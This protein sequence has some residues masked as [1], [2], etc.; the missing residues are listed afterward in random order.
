ME[1][2][3]RLQREG[4]ARFI[5]LSGHA[6]PIARQAARDGYVDV[7]M[8]PVNLAAG[9]DTREMLELCAGLD[10]AVVAMKPFAGGEMFRKS[11]AVPVTAVRCLSYTLSQTGV[12]AVVPGVRDVDEL[13]A[14]QAYLDAPAEARDFSGL[15]AE[16]QHD[17]QGTCVYCNHCLP[18][19]VGIEIAEILRLVKAA[20]DGVTPALR[21]AYQALAATAS[22]CTN[23]GD[24]ER[25]CPFGVPIVERLGR[26]VALFEMA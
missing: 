12:S 6:N 10:V 23:C 8:Q 26:A 3:L 22:G 19:P 5:G 9:A 14:A 7:L 2:A 21:H 13:E 16:L 18:C 11:A 4:K 20:Q 1:L 25:R 15:L 17:L 24:C